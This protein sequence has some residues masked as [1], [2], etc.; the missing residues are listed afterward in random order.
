[1]SYAMTRDSGAVAPWWARSDLAYEKG[2]L[3]FAG[4]SVQALAD[5]SGTPAF[6]Y[7]GARVMENLSRLDRALQ[8]TSL[9]YRVH[10]A[11]KANRFMPLLT[12][13]R[14]SGL[15]GIDACSPGE[16]LLALQCGFEQADISYTNTS[17]SAE[18]LDVLERH[19]EVIINCDS[20][21]SIRRLGER[22]P[23]RAIGIRINPALGV[24]Y[25]DNE[26]LRYANSATTTKFGIYR[27]QFP[28]A[29]K[30]AKRYGLK[31][32]GIHFHTGCGYLSNQLPMWRDILQQSLW[33]IEQLDTPRYVNLGGGLGV[34]HTLM[35][36]PLDLSQWAATIGEVYGERGLKILV[37]PGDYVVK[38]AGM[39][40]LEVNTVEMKR[41]TLFIGVNGG[42]NLAIE[43]AFYGLPCEP[44]PVRVR[45]G[46]PV[47]VNIAGNIN[48]ALDILAKNVVLTPVQEGDVMAFINAGGYAA[49]MSL[50]HCMRGNFREYLLM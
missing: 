48:E 35:D 32:E 16:L 37:E 13:M 44:V 49:A 17:V 30:L 50:N 24:G 45:S 5:S 12:F 25:G 27:E 1:M 39:L 3:Q 36:Q 9:D 6:Y 2:R 29:L 38:D 46:K 18:D 8:S 43:P 42:F 15:C 34:P 7:S 33:F 40:L 20:L 28:E 41:E 19:P 10:Y 26:L 11:M 14:G 47:T 31:V 22:C 23:G 4:R 21:S